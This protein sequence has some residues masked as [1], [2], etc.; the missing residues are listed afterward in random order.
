[1]LVL[2]VIPV[3]TSDQSTP[4]QPPQCALGFLTAWQPQVVR[5]HPQGARTSGSNIMTNRIETTGGF[6]TQPWKGPSITS[7][8]KA[9]IR[10]PRSRGR[11]T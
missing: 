9:L 7:A 4:V 8:F 5:P 2:A 1:M 3:E 6:M 10:P 11:G